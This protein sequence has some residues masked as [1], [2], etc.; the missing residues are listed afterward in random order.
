VSVG[1]LT[2]KYEFVWIGQSPRV[3]SVGLRGQI[4]KVF[5]DQKPKLLMDDLIPRQCYFFSAFSFLFFS[6]VCV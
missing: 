5:D 2:E 6:F 1:C 4:Q 3:A